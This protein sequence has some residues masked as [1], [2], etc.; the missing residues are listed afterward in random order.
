MANDGYT[1]AGVIN[2][3]PSDSED[4]LDF[5]FLNA[6]RNE[7]F[8]QLLAREQQARAPKGIDSLDELLSVEE[9][10]LAPLFSFKQSLLKSSD[11]VSDDRDE[12]QQQVPHGTSKRA[13]NS[14]ETPKIPR[15]RLLQLKKARRMRAR[16]RCRDC[17]CAQCRR[18]QRLKASCDASRDQLRAWVEANGGR[19]P[20][21]PSEAPARSRPCVRCGIKCWDSAL[22]RSRPC[23]LPP[24][25][26][27][28]PHPGSAEAG[29]SG[30]NASSFL[31]TD[32]NAD[33]DSPRHTTRSNHTRLHGTRIQE[34]SSPPRKKRGRHRGDDGTASPA[35]SLRNR[36]RCAECGCSECSKANGGRRKG[37]GKGAEAPPAVCDASSHIRQQWVEVHGG[38]PPRRPA[39]SHLHICL[40]CGAPCWS[41]RSAATSGQVEE[42]SP[43]S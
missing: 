32:A 33:A 15:E 41:R 10:A 4:E 37:R 38:H 5:D 2:D 14:P 23:A 21:Q 16:R 19:L 9:K 1:P 20:R 26:Q 43:N 6:G 34:V 12:E 8:E 22:A 40:R 35:R 27:Q 30:P 28:Q 36:G 11:S 17:G 7:Y 31:D 25:H 3:F 13:A 42:K 39:A 29:L 24:T 18:C